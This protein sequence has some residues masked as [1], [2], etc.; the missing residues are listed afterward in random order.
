MYIMKTN[1]VNFFRCLFE[2][3]RNKIILGIGILFLAVL[4][5]ISFSAGV[6]YDHEIKN[7]EITSSGWETQEQGSW[8][9]DKSGQWTDL[10]EATVT[11]D[12]K[13]TPKNVERHKDV[14]F[15]LDIS[16]S[17][18]GDKIY[19]VINDTLDLSETILQDSNNRV[20]IIVFNSSS[21][22][23]MDFTNNY[24]IVSE[25]LQNLKSSG[26]TNYYDA[27]KDVGTIMGNYEKEEDRDAVVLFLTDGYPGTTGQV[28]EYEYLKSKYPYL[29]I[30]GIQ[31]EMGNIIIEEIKEISDNQY[32]AYIDNLQN[33]LYTAAGVTE[34]YEKFEVTD[35]VENT[36]FDVISETDISVN[37]GKVELITEN[38]KQKIVWNLGEEFL[39][40]QPAKMK[41]K[42]QLKEQ[43]RGIKGF[44][45][46]NEKE[47]IT[48]KLPN[49]DEKLV[50]SEETPVLYNGY[51]VIYYTNPPAGCSLNEKN[52]NTYFEY[53]IVKMVEKDLTGAC[54][55]YQFNGWEV[56][57]ES[58]GD[59][60]MISDDTFVMPAHDVK[61]NAVWTKLSIS[62]SMTGTIAKKKDFIL[63]FNQE[64]AVLDSGLSEFVTSETGIDFSLVPS[65]TN[66]KGLYVKSG[67]ENL[68]YP[69][70]Y[71]RG[72]VK[73]NNVLFANTCWLIVRTTETG[74]TKLIYNGDGSSGVCKNTGANTQT[75]LVNWTE[76][77]KTSAASVG[78]MYNPERLSGSI[79]QMFGDS[80]SSDEINVSSSF[81]KIAVDSWFEEHLTGYKGYLED[82][83]WCNDRSYSGTTFGP[84]LRDT[85]S[86]PALL[87]AEACPNVTDRFTTL[88][89]NGNGALTY[90]AGLITLDE[91][92][93]GGLGTKYKPSDTTSYLFN[94]KTYH[95]MS[96]GTYGGY[97]TSIY[98]ASWYLATYSQG[99]NESSD[100]YG[101][102]PMISLKYGIKASGGT[103][104]QDD[105]Y[106]ID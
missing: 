78:Y 47:G 15:V 26:G 63:E 19:K 84:K 53:E 101:I 23:A 56:S 52:T 96:P 3:R 11:F 85:S 86:S 34:A 62:K 48:S 51:D 76:A 33:T 36:F 93:V 60:R 105:P 28:A 74:G 87:N 39:T 17:M 13:T 9:I 72:N 54:P 95:T 82:A 61:I 57:D 25:Y 92:I 8:H 45:P 7:V 90:P 98:V 75:S 104:A 91:L 79:S 42:L 31:Y 27:L 89:S 16:E 66:G 88:P 24:E 29:T 38:E 46:T 106:T 30:N 55:G 103:G 71:Y 100:G 4:I 5:T 12:L 41:I 43:Y 68:E 83:V 21:E 81:A 58:S 32:L 35:Y 73:N 69:I 20:A 102:R 99:I 67:T 94:K 50:L 14:I 1:I 97:A 59:L 80:N 22:I 37:V 10:Y 77:P 40:G 65:D 44:Y 64:K 70:M 49:D 6:S 18:T 2:S